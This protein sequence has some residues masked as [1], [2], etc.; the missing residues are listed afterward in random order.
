MVGRD[1]ALTALRREVT[2][3]ELEFA[4]VLE[5]TDGGP[6]GFL[7]RVRGGPRLHPHTLVVGADEQSLA[8][9]H[10][11][12]EPL[13]PDDVQLWTLVMWLMEQL[14]TGV[15][16]WGQRIRLT[17][18]TVAIDP[19]LDPEPS[20]P[21]WVSPVPLERP[22][23]AGQRRLR[24]LVR[25]RRRGSVVILGD[26][27]GS[28]PDPAP[29]GQLRDVGFDVRQ[30][31]A[32]HTEGRLVQWLQLYLDDSVASPPAGQLVVAWRNAKAVVQL[33][34]L[35]CKGSVPQGA[36]QGLVL[37]GVQ[38]AADAGAHVIEHRL[39]VELRQLD[40]PWQRED[41]AMRLNAADVP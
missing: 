41:G 28:E 29:G 6:D 22:T 32:A 4:T 26:R 16:R 18:G 25:G 1:E 2:G 7:V 34:H 35:E 39:D 5:V 10:S 21:W 13:P 3:R 24:R 31:R 9:G 11:L 8:L 27:M 12:G 23:R 20:N 14:D 37:A 17:D 19:T 40:L 33:E 36:L 15:L 30:G 38:A